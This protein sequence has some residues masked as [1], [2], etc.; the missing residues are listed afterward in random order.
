MKIKVTRK[1]N[2]LRVIEA[3]QVFNKEWEIQGDCEITLTGFK[4]ANKNQ[5]TVN[6][7]VTNGEI[8]PPSDVDFSVI[9]YQIKE[10]LINRTNEIYCYQFYN[11]NKAAWES[12]KDTRKISGW[13]VDTLRYK[14]QLINLFTGIIEEETEWVDL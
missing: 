13:P 8:I 6:F 9:K 3:Q 2:T 7:T 10:L 12:Y 11:I 4:G 1:N 14:F 5:N